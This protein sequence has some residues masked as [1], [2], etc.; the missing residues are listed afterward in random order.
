MAHVTLRGN[1]VT[2]IGELPALGSKIPTFTLTKADLSEMTNADLADKRTILNIFPSIDT[3]PC[4]M[5]TRKFNELASSLDNTAVICVSADL[6]FAQRRFCG[7]E[8]LKNVQTGSSFRSDFGKAF[9]VTLI[10]SAMKGLLARSVVVLDEQ[11][12]VMYTELVG[13]I[14][15]EPNYEAA[16]SAL[17]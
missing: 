11:G 2:T 16:I 3:P 7:A 17:K 6:P 8:G 5:S 10:D 14:T 1:P 13:E 9:G 12:T 4:A 15:N